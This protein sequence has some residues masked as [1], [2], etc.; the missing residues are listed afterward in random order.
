[1]YLSDIIPDITIDLRYYTTNNFIGTP[2]DGYLAPKCIVTKDASIAIKNVQ[3]ELK[4]YGLCL[5]ILDTYRPQQAVDHFVRWA[6]DYADTLKKAE[7]Y[8]NV[9]K[10]E[11]IPDYIASKSG[12]SRGSTVD[13]TII[14]LNS[15]NTVQIDMGGIFDYFGEVSWVNNMNITPTQRAHRMLLQT[16]MIKHGFRPYSKEWWHFTLQDEPFPNTYFNFPVK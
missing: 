12:H 6:N 10:N 8:P 14:S 15:N 1:V 5:K 7:Y 11:L 3:D 13:L 9:K 4:T 16:L 2:I